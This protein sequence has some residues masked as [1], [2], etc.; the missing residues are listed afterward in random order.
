MFLKIK[1]PVVSAIEEYSSEAA[2]CSDTIPQSS[3]A[4]KGTIKTLSRAKDDSSMEYTYT[5]QHR[6]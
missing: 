4:P 1:A 6:A 2:H 3:A 5:I